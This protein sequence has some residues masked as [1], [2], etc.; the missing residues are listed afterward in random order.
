MIAQKCQKFVQF[1]IEKMEL[2][3]IN[4]GLSVCSS[5]KKFKT[6]VKFLGPK[7]KTIVKIQNPWL[8]TPGTPGTSVQTH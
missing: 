1:L 4:G 5:R 7:I 6:T 2:T 8:G 3:F